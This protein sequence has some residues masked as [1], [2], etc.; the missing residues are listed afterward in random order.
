MIVRGCGTR[1][2]GG[3]YA[4]CRLN[5]NGL[6]VEY[7]VLCP[8]KPINPLDFGLTAINQVVI[9]TNRASHILDW[10][11]AEYEYPV[12]W[13]EEVRRFGMS[14]RCELSPNQ[15]SRI[16]DKSYLITVHARAYIP[17]EYWW[18][19]IADAKDFN[20]PPAYK[21]RDCPRE[22]FG[23]EPHRIDNQRF[24]A[25][26]LWRTVGAGKRFDSDYH[27]TT[28][29]MPS[30]EYEAIYT[31]E[32]YLFKPAIFANLPIHRFVVIED[33]LDGAHERKL[34]KLAGAQIPVDVVKE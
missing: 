15:Y 4:E 8:T 20:M 19:L 25:G 30:F 34:A 32:K 23:I 33:K 7:F 28:R 6:P 22:N 11:G 21:W 26:H 5:D 18:K 24:C 1:K 31:T 9:D 12:D 10:I 27:W 3:V 29:S 13:I 16:T 2:A 14:Q 17:S